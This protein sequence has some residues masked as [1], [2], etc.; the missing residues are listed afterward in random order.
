MNTP[1]LPWRPMVSSSTVTDALHA[2]T[3]QLEGKWPEWLKGTLMRTAPAVFELGPWRA[4]HWFD[5]LGMMFCFDVAA[6]QVAYRQRLLDT[7]A[8]RAARK[9]RVDMSSFGSPNQRGF[10]R[11]LFEPIPRQ[12]DNANVNTV[13]LGDEWHVFTETQH[14]QIVDEATL[15]TLGTVKYADDLPARMTMTAHPHWDFE[16]KRAVNVGATLG[17][18]ATVWAFDYAPGRHER[19]V[20]GKYAALELSYMHAFALTPRELIVI[21]HPWLLKPHQL[22]WSNKGF[23]K[24]FE[25]R[26]ERGSRLL[27]FDR[28]KAEAAPLVFETETVFVFHVAN[29]FHDGEDRVIDVLSYPDPGIAD[30]LRVLSLQPKA[31]PTT[32]ALKRLRIKP[33]G[34]TSVETLAEKAFELPAISY[35]RMNGRRYRFLY[36]STIAGDGEEVVKLDLDSGVRKTFGRADHVYGEPVFVARPGAEA[37][38]DGVVLVVGSSPVRSELTVLDAQSFAPIAQARLELPIPLGFHGSFVGR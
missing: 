32:P 4:E 16:K 35:R 18:E 22:L 21:G 24:H 27:V 33:G 17:R 34:R 23:G 15:E 26:P 38:D 12:T 31:V 5:G 14:Q 7:A 28:E 9:G 13:K 2:A 1:E 30:T 36:G 11:R 19:R 29:A 25:W 6:G 37:E 8:S 20:F 3:P 10:F